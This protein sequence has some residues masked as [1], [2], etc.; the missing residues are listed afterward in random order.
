MRGD[1][2]ERWSEKWSVEQKGGVSESRRMLLR[3][4]SGEGHD[5]LRL[6]SAVKR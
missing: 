3:H 6:Y 4:L 5:V 2:V 1:E